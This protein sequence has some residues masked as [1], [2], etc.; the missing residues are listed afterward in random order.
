MKQI[1]SIGHGT[2]TLEAFL[3]L[4]E[5]FHIQILADIRSYPSSRRHPHFGREALEQALTSRGIRY[6]WLPGLGGYRKSGLGER[7]PHT[8]LASPG[9][10]NYA[11][12]MHTPAFAEAV[13]ELL[14]LA[15]QGTL[16]FM[17][18]ETPPQ[19]CHRLLLSDYLLARGI[20]V[21]HILDEKRVKAH[22]LSRTARIA[23][24]QVI[25]DRHPPAA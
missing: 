5:K 23:E 11:D 14:R 10:R 17:C 4:L 19:K 15:S 22:Q 9:F 21:I 2:R 20:Q 13:A 7:S 18:A 25:Y 3:A 6:V 8:A 24:G 1:Y 16:C 12:Y